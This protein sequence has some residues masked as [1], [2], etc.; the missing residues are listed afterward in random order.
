MP[1]GAYRVVSYA[2]YGRAGKDKAERWM[3]TSS[4]MHGCVELTVEEK[5]T[6]PLDLRPHF[7][8]DA[9]AEA[10]DGKAKILYSQSDPHGNVAT[11][12]VNGDVRLPGYRVFDADGR[13][14]HRGVFENT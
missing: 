5:K 11:L 9:F 10:K 12:S 7:V 3:M 13:P 1:A 8:G 14:V 6:V 2:L 4:N